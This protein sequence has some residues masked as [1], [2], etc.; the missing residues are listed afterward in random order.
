[1]RVG[2]YLGDFVPDVGGG[3]TFVSEVFGAL[4]KQASNTPHQFVVLC[5][6]EYVKKQKSGNEN[7]SLE[8]CGVPRKGLVDTAIGVLKYY[9]PLFA[10]LWRWPGRLERVAMSR[11][12]EFIWFVGGGTYDAPEIP[13]A[14]TVWDLQHRT[15]PWF[16]EVSSRG[17]WDYRELTY[18]RFL[19]R[20]ARVITGTKTGAEQLGLYFQIP[21]DRISI[22]PH[23]TPGLP[24]A[25]ATST[26]RFA[27][28]LG[29]RKFIFYPA[30]FWPHK[31]H[32][33]LLRALKLLREQHDLD[34]D[35]VLT[36]SEKGNLGHVKSV[37]EQLG[38][39][40]RIHFLGFVSSEELAWLYG[41]AIALVYPSFSGPENLPPLEAF[42]RGCP[43]VISDYPGACE[44]L[45]DAAVFFDPH[46]PAQMAE[47]IK[48]LLDQPDLRQDLVKKG[49]QRAAT[50]TA[51][52]YVNG[53][54]SM[55]DEFEPVRRCWA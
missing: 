34:I 53:V 54:F 47:V 49:Y 45:G 35:L 19:R 48:R 26:L 39:A 31:N 8:Y 16:P 27:T 24:D 28:E 2:V 12:V 51:E 50:W 42:S 33:N 15:H 40:P 30:Q 44:Q 10:Y 32:V 36:G 9:S 13:Y 5:D 4:L 23:P 11:G 29:G 37:V 7:H 17:R 3:Y 22:L 18:S 14:A 41:R 20:A 55:L 1:M 52:D 38:L 21:H 43:V 6:P 46:S 25:G